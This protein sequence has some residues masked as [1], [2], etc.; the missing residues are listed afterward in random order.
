MV[1]PSSF[2]SVLAR[3]VP[4]IRHL[5]PDTPFV[6]AGTKLDLVD[7]A[8]IVDQLRERKEEP[9]TME[10]GWQ[11]AREV[12]AASFVAYSSLTGQNLYDLFTVAVEV[13]LNPKS[14]Q[15]LNTPPSKSSCLMQ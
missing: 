8:H 3:W 14:K 11:L 4:E 1:N 5:C 12:G 2:E 9:I 15:A 10:K 13:G 6:L 7:D